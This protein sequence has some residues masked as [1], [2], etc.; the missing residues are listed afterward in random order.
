MRRK[1][2]HCSIHP[3]RK[4]SWCFRPEMARSWRRNGRSPAFTVKGISPVH[5]PVCESCRRI[6]L[7]GSTLAFVDWL[8]VNVYQTAM[9][10]AF[11]EKV[12]GWQIFKRLGAKP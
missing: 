9:T 10:A 8:L 3:G 2:T 7:A 5:P 6:T 4:G 12:P 11:A 1:A